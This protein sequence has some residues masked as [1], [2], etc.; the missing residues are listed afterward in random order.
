MKERKSV[1]IAM[2]GSGFAANLHA[3]AY[4]KIVGI[5]VEVVGVAVTPQGK[6]KG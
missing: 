5:D 4:K 6:K 3:E 1:K 2:I